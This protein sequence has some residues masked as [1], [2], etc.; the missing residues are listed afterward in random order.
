MWRMLCV[1]S[2][3][4]IL[5]AV[6]P[7]SAQ[8]PPADKEELKKIEADLE[9][10]RSQIQD[11]ES[12]LKKLKGEGVKEPKR[13]F[14]FEDVVRGPLVATVGATGTLQA[15]ET[16]DIGAQVQGKIVSIGADKNTQSGNIDWG[17][18]VEGPVKDKAGKIIKAG[19]ILARIDSTLYE[20]QRNAAKASVLSA[21][22]SVKS[23]ELSVISAEADILMKI[24][25][26]A[27]ATKDLARGEALIKTGGI[28]RAEYDQ[29][30]TAF[31][32][33]TANLDV[34]KANRDVAKAQVETAKAQ[35]DLQQANLKNAQTNLDYCTIT[36]PVSGTVIDRRVNVG[37]TVV[38]SLSAPSLFLIAEDLKKLEVWATVN[39]TDVG[40]IKVGQDVKYTVDA[41]PGKVY[42]GKVVPQGKLPYRLKATMTSNVVTYTVVVSAANKDG[43]LKPYMTVN[44]SFIVEKKDNALL[45]P[46]AALRWQPALQQ[47]APDQRASYIRL[48]NKKRSAT[49]PDQDQGLLWTRGA[50]GFVH[51]TQVRI[52]LSD[53]SRTEILSETG[54]GKLPEHTP[55]VVGESGAESSRSDGSNPFSIQMFKPKPKD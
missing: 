14:R 16:V 46:N 55:V 12:R 38:A 8:Q 48:K 20:A 40:R 51:Y 52:G 19:T 21:L 15:E 17:S 32:S 22:A 36:A 41:M 3:T 2:L 47:I 6:Q 9:K 29:F 26:L 31:D 11:L 50:D 35:V 30:K 43:A 42:H 1:L 34:S 44:M 18:E 28:Q 53:G 49:D 45:V 37:Q 13:T 25:T 4:A 7:V 10:L 24:P 39:E 27:Q 54:D 23:A 5:G 33:A